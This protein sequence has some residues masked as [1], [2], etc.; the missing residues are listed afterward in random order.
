[1]L[2]IIT[3]GEEVLSGQIIDSNAAWLSTQLMEN[4]LEVT[5]RHTVGDRIKDLVELFLERSQ[6]AQVVIVNGGLGPTSDDLSAE[7]AAQAAGLPL[8][9]CSEWLDLLQIRADKEAWALGKSHVQQALLP[10]DCEWIYNYTGSACGFK[11]RINA[12]DFYFTPGPPV[13][14]KPMFSQEI[15]PKI[16]EQ[17]GDG[18][19]NLLSRIHVFGIGEG[20]ITQKISDLTLPAGCNLGF[21]PHMPLVEVK[22]MSRG[23]KGLIEDSHQAF[24][25][26]LAEAL[27]DNVIGQNDE[28]LVSSIDRFMR[29]HQMTLAVAESCTGGL[30]AHQIVQHSGV[31]DWF[32]RGWISYSN[33]AKRELLGV[34]S[35]TLESHG[36][37]SVQ[38]AIEMAQGA[39]RQSG[40]DFGLSVSGISGPA[41]GTREKPVGTVAIA[42]SRARL[43]LA[44]MYV[45]RDR[46]R[47]RNQEMLAGLALDSL[48]RFLYGMDVF[49]EYTL[50]QCLERYESNE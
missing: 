30:I 3:T 8:E 9:S 4:G 28:T 46:G 1:M 7:A 2:E 17:Y 41:G 29:E 21:R 14:L 43:N 40:C 11:L 5:R 31:S 47:V 16:I 23:G 50:G 13:E 44:A 15:L 25:Q 20:S 39:R 18:Q 37:V 33:D 10:A 36:A 22:V 49:P 19:V 34:S 6:Q 24:S 26:S 45:H 48:R 35:S 12:C 38:T 32:D 27:G 42:L